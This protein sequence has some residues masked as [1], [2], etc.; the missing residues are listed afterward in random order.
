MFR[1]LGIWCALVL[2]GLGVVFG[3][4]LSEAEV[5]GANVSKQSISFWTNL[6]TL[7]RTPQAPAHSSQNLTTKTLSLLWDRSVSL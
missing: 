2:C 3:F 7:S 4:R 5:E 6:A 1:A